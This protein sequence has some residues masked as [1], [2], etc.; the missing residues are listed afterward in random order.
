MNKRRK[1]GLLF[2][3]ANHANRTTNATT[4]AL[5]KLWW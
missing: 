3:S 4:N 5:L 1:E 2:L